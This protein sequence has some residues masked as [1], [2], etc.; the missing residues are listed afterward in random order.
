[1]R[2]VQENYQKS[3]IDDV[4]QIQQMAREI[5]ARQFVGLD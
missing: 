3:H 1:M 5:Q 4:E 2:K